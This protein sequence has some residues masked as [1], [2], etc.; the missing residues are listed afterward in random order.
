MKKLILFV[1]VCILFGAGNVMAQQNK[2][3]TEVT[4]FLGI[5]VDGTKNQMI[6]KIKAKG[7]TY[8]QKQDRLKGKF[9]GRDVYVSVVTNKNKVWRIMVQDVVP[10]SETNIKI[11]FN[12]LCRQFA[13]NEKY[14]PQNL[15]GNYEIESDEDISYNITVRNKRY[16][17]GYFQMTEKDKEFLQDTTALM[18]AVKPIIQS[19]YTEEELD[20]PTEEITQDVYNI[21]ADYLFENLYDRVKNRSVWFLIN[22]FY[23]D[24]S[25]IMYYDNELNKARG[26]DL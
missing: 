20:N 8:N 5:P 21:A 9:N 22:E 4:K 23:G 25:I 10:S 1:A 16:E 24:Y 13:E 18:N 2:N 15:T 3:K 7:F 12:E 11:R 19:K 6:Q 14:V 26:E 17:A